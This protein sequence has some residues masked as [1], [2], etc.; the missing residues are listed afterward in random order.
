MKKQSG[1]EAFNILVAPDS[2]KGSLSAGDVAARIAAGIRKVNSRCRIAELAI[3]DGGEGT[4]QAVAAALHGDWYAVD[5]T[6]ANGGSVRIPYAVCQSAAFGAFAI[7]DVA[8]A[9]GLPA[10]I[11]PPGKRTTQGLGQAIRQI[12]DAGQ[13]C[14]VLGLGGSSTNDGGA[15]MLAEVAFDFLDASGA[16]LTP[17]LD[18]LREIESVRARPDGGWLD[19]ITLLGLTDVTSPLTGLAGA[20]HVFGPQKG[21]LDPASAD[22]CLM[23][24]SRKCEAFTG[25]QCASLAGSGAAGGIGFALSLLGASLIPGAHFILDALG[26]TTTIADFDWV[27]TGEGRSDHQT[28]LGKG[29]ALVAELARKHGVPVTLLSG[30][31]ADDADLHAAFDGCFSIQSG[32]ISLR[33]AIDNAGSLIETASQQLATLFFRLQQGRQC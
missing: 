30:A 21:V 17:V 29:P 1:R 3:A 5:V 6:D 13:S 18:N 33:D 20:S 2:F 25:K 32:P 15:G 19:G 22:A 23:H 28:L 11:A 24:F 9:V 4:A 14:I 12:A 10:A 8:E 7:F 31:I 27:I 26:V 16:G